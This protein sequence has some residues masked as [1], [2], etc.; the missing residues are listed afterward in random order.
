MKRNIVRLIVAGLLMAAWWGYRY[1]NHGRV[2]YGPKAQRINCISNLK[3]IG[4]AFKLWQDDRGDQYPFNV[5]TNAGGTRERCA[6]DQE[7]FDRNAYLSLQVMSNEL[8]APKL[9]VCPRDKSRKMATNWVNLRA[10][11]ITYR[12][13]CGT[14][15]TESNPKAVLAVCPVDGNI[16]YADGTVKGEPVVDEDGRQAM[17]VSPDFQPF[18]KSAVGTNSQQQTHAP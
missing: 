15:V 7:G 9:L 8:T 2:K 11:N 6:P 18:Q 12:F 14:N 17:E 1:W 16:L 4:I 5:S 10:E 13:R 3:Q